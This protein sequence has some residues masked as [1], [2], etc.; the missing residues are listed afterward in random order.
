MVHILLFFEGFIETDKKN[1][2][3]FGP[4]NLPKTKAVIDE[5]KMRY[6]IMNIKL[7]FIVRVTLIYINWCLATF[8]LK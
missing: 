2:F 4:T 1:K 8:E 7:M 6:F 3:D 5:E